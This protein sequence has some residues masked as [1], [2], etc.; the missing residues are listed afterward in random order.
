MFA[1]VNVTTT[2]APG[3]SNITVISA[4]YGSTSVRVMTTS[5]S[6]PHLV[7]QM[8]P[9]SAPLSFSGS[10]GI[11]VAD[12]ADSSGNPVPATQNVA[13]TVNS[14]C[15]LPAAFCGKINQV[16]QLLIPA[17]GEMGTKVISATAN[18]TIGLTASAPGFVPVSLQFQVFSVPAQPS[19][20]LTGANI[21]SNANAS[22]T[23]KMVYLGFGLPGANV[24]VSVSPAGVA[25][26]C[27]APTRCSP[28]LS[29]ATGS[30]GQVSFAFNPA[31]TFTGS[32]TV[33]IVISSSLFGTITLSRTILV[34]SPPAGPPPS[35]FQAHALEVE[36][37]VLVVVL[38]LV[39]LSVWLYLRRRSRIK[40]LLGEQ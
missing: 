2:S 6:A 25:N 18:G 12:L 16:G 33:N 38:I 9:G 39:G 1:A 8:L 22:F 29:T 28:T 13:I 32:A 11:L 5:L 30:A 4:G 10:Q 27:T 26:L 17:G 40:A 7:L 34:A 31:S 19:L 14:T 24:A 3:H 23:L 37:A 36:V 15:P 21:F 20:A 35:F